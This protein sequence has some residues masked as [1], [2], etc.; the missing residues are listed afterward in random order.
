LKLAH[1]GEAL[2]PQYRNAPLVDVTFEARFLGELSVETRRDVFQREIKD[3]YPLLFVPN[4]TMGKAPALQH[5]QFRRQDGSAR[6]SLALNSFAYNTTSYPGFADFRKEL[7]RVFGILLGTFEISN[8]TRLGLRYVNKMALIREDDGTIPLKKYV[9]TNLKLT[10]GFPGAGIKN[11]S[12]AISSPIKEGEMN[13]LLDCESPS[14]SG[15]P[16]FL[17]LDFDFYTLKQSARSE[18][19]DFVDSA[20]EQIESTFLE[21]I[22]ED[23]LAIM[24]GANDG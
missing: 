20:H 13:L 5:Y 22:S 15:G 9:S 18:V 21:I 16:E 8:F 4:A 6:I 14:P 7:D 12:L 17:L 3:V 1:N 19:F 24:K 2:I 23:Y 10:P 11:L